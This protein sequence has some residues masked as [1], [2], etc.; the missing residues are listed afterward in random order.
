M[1]QLRQIQSL[2]IVAV[3][4]CTACKDKK[5]AAPVTPDVRYEGVIYIGCDI[6]PYGLN[7]DSLI[8]MCT[9]IVNRDQPA[10]SLE[11]GCIYDEIGSGLSVDFDVELRRGDYLNIIEM[12]SVKGDPEIIE[13][14]LTLAGQEFQWG[15]FPYYSGYQLEWDMVT[16]KVQALNK[17]VGGCFHDLIIW[18]VIVQ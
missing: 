4:L 12:S 13:I 5:V 10:D 8:H 14:P 15:E 7:M 17:W 11:M 16:L 9:S 3:V 2:F 18:E 1:L 6:G